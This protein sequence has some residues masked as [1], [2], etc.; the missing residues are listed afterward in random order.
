MIDNLRYYEKRRIRLTC[1]DGDVF[2]GFVGDWIDP[3]DNDNGKPSIILDLD[4]GRLIEFYEEEISTI[5][6][7]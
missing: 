6:E 7:L 2:E 3:I 1:P 5:E 4:D